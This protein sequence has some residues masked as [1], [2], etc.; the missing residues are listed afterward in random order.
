MTQAKITTVKNIYTQE[1]HMCYD[2][3]FYSTVDEVN[4]TH[5]ITLKCY[6]YTTIL[7]LTE[8]EVMNFRLDRALSDSELQDILRYNHRKTTPCENDDSESDDA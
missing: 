3:Q 8:D 7:T 1:N 6:Y 4:Y 2:P 5:T